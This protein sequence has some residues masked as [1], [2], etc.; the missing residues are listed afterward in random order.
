MVG[1]VW[2]GSWVCVWW[3][4]ISVSSVR[5]GIRC[6]SLFPPSSP[7]PLYLF[8][9]LPLPSLSISFPDI[10][11]YSGWRFLMILKW[12]VQEIEF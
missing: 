9:L 10:D 8:S 3:R 12:L 11:N 1:Y 6:E 7:L 2:W 4:E 5:F